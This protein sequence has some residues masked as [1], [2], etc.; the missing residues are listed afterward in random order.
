M[1][2]FAKLFETEEYG[3][4]VVIKCDGEDGEPSIE[5]KAKPNSMGVCTTRISFKDTDAGWDAQDKAFEA[6][7]EDEAKAGV[8]DIFKLCEGL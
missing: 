7:T 6:I 5:F 1:K 2:K 8:A 4:I 3:Q